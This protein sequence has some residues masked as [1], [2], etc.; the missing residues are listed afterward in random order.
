MPPACTKRPHWGRFLFSVQVRQDAIRKSDVM[1]FHRKSSRIRSL[2]RLNAF[3][4]ALVSYQAP[5][6][7]AETIETKGWTT[8]LKKDK[9]KPCPICGK[10]P[11][12]VGWEHWRGDS[13]CPFLHG[14][15]EELAY[16]RTW[17]WNR[18][19][20]SFER[21]HDLY[22]G[23]E[24]P[25]CHKI[26]IVTAGYDGDEDALRVHVDCD[27]TQSEGADVSHAVNLW[28]DRHQGKAD[29]IERANRQAVDIA[30]KI[31]GA[32]SDEYE[33]CGPADWTVRFKLCYPQGSKPD[34]EGLL[35]DPDLD[36]TKGEGDRYYCTLNLKAYDD[37][38]ALRQLANETSQSVAAARHG[39][40]LFVDKVERVA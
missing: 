30:A 32:K 15:D 31:P 24:C 10:E 27:C 2:L 19:V 5:H 40:H 12:L 9:F 29:R 21:F 23:R 22:A 3:P 33:I 34:R 18:C 13:Y 14:Y 17:K 36:L 11:F 6:E 25:I 37:G 7:G 26:V 20:E 16:G 39:F 38:D 35:T 8:T 1:T 28:L 4:D